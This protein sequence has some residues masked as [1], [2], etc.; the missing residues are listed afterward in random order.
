MADIGDIGDIGAY[1]L[2]IHSLVSTSSRYIDTKNDWNL[3][4]G[5]KELD[6]WNLFPKK[7]K[8]YKY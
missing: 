7:K 4:E 6:K 2:W 8:F 3:K 5:K 1:V